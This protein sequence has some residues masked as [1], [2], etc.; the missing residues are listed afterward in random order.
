M[1]DQA[2]SQTPSQPEAYTQRANPTFDAELALRT[3]SREAAFFVPHLRPGMH[4]LDI[5]CG[6][7]T[8]TLGLAEIIAPG[9]VVGIDMR[10]EPLAQARAAAT[11][12][13]LVNVRFDQGSVYELPF[14][15]GSF[16]AAFAHVVL[17][18][19]REPVRALAE[20]RR[21]LRPGGMV[22]VRDPDLGTI[23]TFP[24]TPL[25]ERYRELRADTQQHNGGDPYLGRRH[26]QLLLE[27]GFTR[28]E[29]GA[30][31]ASF[32]TVD[33]TRRNAAFVKAQRHGVAATAVAEGWADEATLDAMMTEVDAWA[34]RPDA[35]GAVIWCHAVGWVEG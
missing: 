28:A 3:A 10:P 18:H 33:E 11:T 4:L 16:D 15:D 17:M 23:L 2:Q 14:P 27:A 9:E 34:E 8:I 25:L 31:A 30:T 6:P 22:G 12:Q 26:R 5:G 20:V 19:L 21:V 7:G 32:G 24:L 29:A 1:T 13:K 35:F